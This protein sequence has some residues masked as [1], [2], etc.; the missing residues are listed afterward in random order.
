M[1]PDHRVSGNI[2]LTSIKRK[3]KMA[4]VL[5]AYECIISRTHVKE[6]ISIYVLRYWA[7]SNLRVCFVYHNNATWSKAVIMHNKRKIFPCLMPLSDVCTRQCIR[8]DA[9][10]RLRRA[11]VVCLILACTV[12]AIQCVFSEKI[13]QNS[14][15]FSQAKLPF[16]STQSN[17]LEV[18][19]SEVF[20][21]Y[22][23]LR[24]YNIK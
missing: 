1:F 22:S 6:F 16:E 8:A 23:T 2:L 21:S 18:T 20:A 13:F 14:L 5:L 15:L 12:P 24:F 10:M 4:G 7:T 19:S 3:H 11:C 17:E 9:S